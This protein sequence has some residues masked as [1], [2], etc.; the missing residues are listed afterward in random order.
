MR[1][2]KDVIVA[3]RHELEAALQ[4][5]QDLPFRNQLEADRIILTMELAV[6]EETGTSGQAGLSFGV[7]VADV[8]ASVEAN[9]KR[10]RTKTHTLTIEFKPRV[11][12]PTP[13]GTTKPFAQRVIEAGPGE[14]VD[15]EAEAERVKLFAMVFGAPGGFY[16][17]NR[18]EVF[19]AAVESLTDHGFGLLLA[20]L[21][22]QPAPEDETDVALAYGQIANI[23]RSG[24]A[25]SVTK[26]GELLREALAGIERPELKRLIETTFRNE[27]LSSDLSPSET[28][29]VTGETAATS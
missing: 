21:E 16:S 8:N 9:R 19:I 13:P 7:V 6:S 29:A 3:L 1:P 12:Q 27:G 25:A 23:L 24:P 4:A 26:G 5:N 14:S 2:L 28:P 20:A 15:R 11:V 18:A 10:E 22:G 17:H